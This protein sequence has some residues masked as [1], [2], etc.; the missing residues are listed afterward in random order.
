MELRQLEYF[1][2]ASRLSS[3]TRAAERLHVSQ[4]SITKA[5]QKLEAEL[6]VQLFD[7]S[8]KNLTLTPEGSVFLSRIETAL[9]NIEDAL[10][11]LKDYQ[12]LQKGTIKIG[13]PP[14]IG[15]YLFPGI[16]SSF[17][18][19]YPKL[20]TFISE[21]GS[22]AILEQLERGE[23]DVGLAIVN[24]TPLNLNI[25]PLADHQILVCLPQ[26]HKLAGQTVLTVL[27]LVDQPLIMLKDDSYH[28][29]LLMNEFAKQQITP[30]IILSSSQI[31]TIKGL[32]ASGTGISFFLDV[33]AHK[34]HALIAIPFAEPLTVTIGLVWKKDKYLSRASRGF[35]DFIT[36]Y[37][38]LY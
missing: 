6:E 5:I 27:D 34:D 38:N 4:P 18:K 33:I 23:L 21:E 29:R 10:Y 12:Q 9:H 2:M 16:F 3:I 28:R 31:E 15:S 19:L 7:R 37:R 35:I 14:M 13:I 1:Q 26:G 20:E 17:Q 22:L 25:M 30:R 11:E 36:N 24:E 8:Q 32:V